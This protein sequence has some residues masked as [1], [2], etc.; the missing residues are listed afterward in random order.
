MFFNGENLHPDVN[1]SNTPFNLSSTYATL[2]G[3]GQ[4]R[5]SWRSRA[6][7]DAYTRKGGPSAKESGAKRQGDGKPSASHQKKQKG[8]DLACLNTSDTLPKG[9]CTN[10]HNYQPDTGS[11]SNTAVVTL[12]MQ[13]ENRVVEALVDTGAKAGNYVNL[14]TLE[15]LR[16]HGVPVTPTDNSL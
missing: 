7:G 16:D 11:L 14:E 13:G 9:E 2:Q 15:W 6:N 4:E 3:Q 8:E 12:S 10:C 1:K 5:L